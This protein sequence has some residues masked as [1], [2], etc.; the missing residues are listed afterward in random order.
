LPDKQAAL[1]ELII[2]ALAAYWLLSFFG[3]SIVPG[4]PYTAHFV[5]LLAVVIVV[6]IILL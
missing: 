4:V 3:Q 6:P 1:L 2:L 5:D